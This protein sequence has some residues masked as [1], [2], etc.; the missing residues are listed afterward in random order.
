MSLLYNVGTSAPV[1]CW[2][3][4]GGY[5]MNHRPLGAEASPTRPFY[6]IASLGI[7]P[8]ETAYATIAGMAAAHV[9]EIVRIEPR[10]PYLLWGYTFGALVAFETAWRL[11]RISVQIP[12]VRSTP[13]DSGLPTDKVGRPHISPEIF[14]RR[15]VTADSRVRAV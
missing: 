2:P 4:L 9:A 8:A 3:G 13:A 5:P 15:V 11:E 7:N 10:G 14:A 1:F 12:K 6:G